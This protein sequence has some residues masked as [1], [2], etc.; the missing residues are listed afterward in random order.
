MGPDLTE[1]VRFDSLVEGAP[2]L[3]QVGED[4]AI[5]VRR[6][7][8]V[9]AI[10]ATCTH[11]GGPL[12]EG[13][14]VGETIRCPWH[15]AC[16]DLR[17]GEAEGAPALSPVACYSVERA[18]GL[19][20]VTGKR[21]T[22]PSA[23]P[24]QAP[25]AVVIV[26][27]GAAGA[28][29][30]ETL[31]RK[32]Y[33]GPV[34]MIGAEEPGPVNRPNLSKDYLAGNAPEEWIPL[35]TPDYYQSIGVALI[36]NNPASRMDTAART[37]TLRDGRSVSYG[38]LLLATGSEA[39]SLPIEGAGLPHVYR[40]RTLADSRAIIAAAERAKR[41]VVI[42]AS[43][44]G[45]EAA[46]SL[47]HRGLEVAVVGPESIPLARIMGPEVGRFIQGLHEANG[48]RFYLEETPA[49]I[50]ENRVELKSGQSMEAEMVVLGV[51]VRPRTEL[52]EAAGLQVDNGIAVD[53]RL[54]TSAPDVYAAG[55][56]ANHRGSRIEHWAVAERQ[57]QAVARAML[58][59]GGP[60][61]DVPFFWSQHYDVT[62][63]YVGHAP[64]WDSLQVLGDLDKRDAAV[65]YR[66]AGRVLAVATVGRDR[67]SL[68]VEA[69]LENNDTRALEAAL[70]E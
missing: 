56:V 70:A 65:V 13:L 26:G 37:V 28:A 10:G 66:A 32:G 45:L 1:G 51:G 46:A 15:H 36:V 48:V 8:E 57:G 40:L 20:K 6:G 2:L 35:R 58:G 27:A 11:Y 5:L 50:R 67:T 22:Q 47:R 33:K 59:L 61:R 69:A 55:D 41:C 54:R 25:S 64:S 7:Q 18:G 53:E 17:T 62:I 14:V 4:P 44:I 23:A 38:A 29:C 24:P 34:T 42:G 30:V 49:A 21:E 3:G 31:R 43:F 12:S 19:V 9:F 16:F 60:Y 68:A 63:S 39:R 52:A